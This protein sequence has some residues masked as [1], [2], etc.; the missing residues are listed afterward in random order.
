MGMRW[1]GVAVAVVLLG[2]V[3]GCAGV[4]VNDLHPPTSTVIAPSGLAPNGLSPIASAPLAGRSAAQLHVVGGFTTIDVTAGVIGNDLFRATTAPGSGQIPVASVTG[5]V[6]TVAEHGTSTSNG[7]ATI[8]IVVN[9][10]ATWSVSLDGGASVAV[11]DLSGAR[12]AGVDVTQGVSSLEL[13]LP[14]PQGTTQL[15]LA[16]GA[17]QV[18]V[19]LHGTEPVRA[20]LS[21]GAGSVTIDGSTTSG[22]AAGSTFASPG[23]ATAPDRVDIACSA[24]VGSVVVDRV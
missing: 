19:N 12:V 15:A 6:V 23:W 3:A 24:G 9:P 8:Q 2:A 11:I 17:S 7:V 1:L 16:A 4:R 10:L 18:R 22:I 13:T 5:D 21:S 14:A 20:T